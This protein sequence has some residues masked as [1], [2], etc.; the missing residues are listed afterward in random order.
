MRSVGRRARRLHSL[1]APHH[2]DLVE[3]N[4]SYAVARAYAGTATTGAA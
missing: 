3:R 4:F 1:A 2:P